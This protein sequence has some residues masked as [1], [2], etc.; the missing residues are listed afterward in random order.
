[1]GT[2]WQNFGG[3]HGYSAALV[4]AARARG[5]PYI[6]L[7]IILLF[8]KKYLGFMIKNANPV[9]VSKG[10]N[11]RKKDLDMLSTCMY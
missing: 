4:F 11:Q 8:I 1:M 7:T 9:P 2:H 3:C 10:L 6:S 5:W